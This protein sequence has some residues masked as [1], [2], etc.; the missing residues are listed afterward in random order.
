MFYCAS[1]DSVVLCPNAEPQ[2][3]RGLTLN[4]LASRLQKQKARSNPYLVIFNFIGYFTLVLHEFFPF[5]LPHD[6]PHV[7]ISQVLSLCYAIP[8]S[9]LLSQDSGLVCFLLI[10]LPAT[11]LPSDLNVQCNSHQLPNDIHHKHWKIY[12][13]FH[14]ETQETVKSQGNTQQKEQCWRYHNT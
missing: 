5:P 2:E 8:T 1:T 4:T 11:I 9:L 6:L 10:L 14:L 3:Q 13:N 12:P 7:H